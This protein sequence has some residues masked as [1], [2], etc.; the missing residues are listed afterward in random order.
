[1][2]KIFAALALTAGGIATGF[3]LAAGP[4]SSAA[5][6]PGHT[7]AVTQNVT[8]PAGNPCVAWHDSGR[9]GLQQDIILYDHQGAPIWWCNNAGGCWAGN[10]RLGVTG[11]SPFD[12]AA[13][14]TTSDGVHGELVIDGQKLDGKDIAF[15]VCLNKGGTLAGCENGG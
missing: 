13:Y 2:N 1:M 6:F 7:A 5:T 3:L 4:A 15:L 9:G 14:L 11:A 8:C 12:D 10:D